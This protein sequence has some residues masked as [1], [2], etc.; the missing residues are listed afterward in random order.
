ME[1]IRTAKAGT[2]ESNDIYIL[3]AQ[4][5]GIKIE[6][7]SPVMEQFGDRI[8]EVI[9]DTLKEYQ[10]KNVF[11]KAEDKGALDFT[12]KARVETAIKRAGK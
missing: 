7:D 4:N 12:I 5:E 10:V 9:E 6:I 11:I 8:R 2:F 1:I 3:I